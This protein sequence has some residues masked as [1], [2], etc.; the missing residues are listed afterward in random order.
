MKKLLVL[1]LVLGLAS[2][3]S[4]GLAVGQVAASDPAGIPVG[5]TGVVNIASDDAE[6]Y[7]AWIEIAD[8]SIA[9]YAVEPEFTEA[10]NPNGNSTV[11]FW[12]GYDGWYDI[13]VASTDP[14]VPLVAGDQI[15]VTLLGI[16]EGTTQLNLYAGDGAT[17]LGSTDVVVIP[18]P[19]TIALLGLGGLFLRRRR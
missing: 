6:P 10:G 14:M 15:V 1:M 9:D 5:E 4:A 17:L 16:A 8:Q 12:E 7:A 11:T 13:L 19:M 2:A 18:E 3:A